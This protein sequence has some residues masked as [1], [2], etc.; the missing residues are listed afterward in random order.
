MNKHAYLIVANSN[1]L[2]LRTCLRMIDDAR[3]DIYLLLD[4][5]AGI[6]EDIIESLKGEVILSKMIVSNSLS[7]NWGGYSQIEAV[8]VL[9]KSALSSGIEYRYLHFFQGSD[10]PIKTQDEIHHFFDNCRGQQ[11]ISVEKS[12]SMMAESKCWYRHFFCHNRFYRKNRMMKA[13]NFA[14]VYLQ[15]G[16]HIRYNTDIKLYQGSALF[17]ITKGF[18]EYLSK[19]EEE[20]HRR[21]RWSLAADECFVQTMA[22]KSEYKDFIEGIEGQ[23]S[24]NARLIDRTRPDGKNSPHVWRS[25]ELD[26]ILN[27]PTNICFARKFDERIDIDI[28]KQIEIT[29]LQHRNE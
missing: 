6:R 22:M 27:Q 9:L 19:N 3:N 20:I 29:L 15:K 17:S 2:V 13:L 16:L 21:F 18:A 26:F 28:V 10:L 5:K 14:F 25:D 23:T 12:R 7:I 11:F 1:L 8:L 24:C 4:K